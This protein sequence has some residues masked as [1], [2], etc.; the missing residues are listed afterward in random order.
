MLCQRWE[1]FQYCITLKQLAYIMKQHA[2]SIVYIIIMSFLKFEENI[3]EKVICYKY[4][5]WPLDYG[6]CIFMNENVYRLT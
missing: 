2:M 4:F 6:K 1:L 3:Q 5:H